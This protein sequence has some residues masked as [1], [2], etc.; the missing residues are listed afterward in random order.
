M[1]T[2]LHGNT[3]STRETCRESSDEGTSHKLIP[4]EDEVE[5]LRFTHRFVPSKGSQVT[6]LLLHGTGG[7]ENNLLPLGS[8]LLP[9]AALLSPRGRV[10][11]N[12]MP[13]FFR[14][15]PEGVF[16]REDLKEQTH[17]L[18]QFVLNASRTYHFNIN[19]VVAVGY[20]NGANIAS[21]TLLLHPHLLKGAVLFR[22]MGIPLELQKIPD[23]SGT[24]VLIE[25]GTYDQII[26]RKLSEELAVLLKT[27]KADVALHWQE[28]DHSLTSAELKDAREWISSQGI[29]N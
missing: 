1:A 23:L 16:D 17:E 6:L 19:K 18:A 24:R 15:S 20:S 11:E 26:P 3:L 21:S 4:S 10:L 28:S 8:D 2:K 13:R 25:S 5:K 7:D 12:G 29:W 22:P 9:G 27:A 14:R